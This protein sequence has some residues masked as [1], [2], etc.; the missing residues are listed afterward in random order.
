MLRANQYLREEVDLLSRG[1][2]DKDYELYGLTGEN[3]KLRDRIEVLETI[4][5]ATVKDGSLKNEIEEAVTLRH[6]QENK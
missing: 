2:E 6:L 3:G 4:V 5:K 1:I